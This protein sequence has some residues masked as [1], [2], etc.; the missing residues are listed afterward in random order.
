[1]PTQ[2]IWGEHDRPYNFEQVQTLWR[3]I[4]DCSLAVI[5]RASHAAHLEQ[6]ALF[7]EILRATIGLND[8]GRAVG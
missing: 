6:P 5:P 1:M 7:H 2:L 3:G 8:A 4:A